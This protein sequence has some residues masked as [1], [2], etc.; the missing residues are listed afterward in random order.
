MLWKLTQLTGVTSQ[1]PTWLTVSDMQ[2]VLHPLQ[3]AADRL[4]DQVEKFAENLDRMNV[5]K[6]QTPQKDCRTVLPLVQT[7]RSIAKA[8]VKSLEK[9]TGSN[10]QG[11]LDQKIKR[12]L[13]I[14]EKSSSNTEQSN[15]PDRPATRQDLSRWKQEEQTWHLLELMLQVEFPLQDVRGDRLS[16][17]KTLKRPGKFA[18]H[19]YS[20]EKEVWDCFLANDD[21]AWERHTVVEWLKECA[22]DSDQDIASVVKQLENDA[23]RGDG[24]WA[25]SWL[26]TKEA[27][28][29]QKRLR[30]WPRALNPDIEPSLMNSE[31]TKPLVTQLDPDA[32]SRQDRNLELKDQNFERATW[33]A[34]WEMVRRGN[35]WDY[36]RDW[37]QERVDGWRAIAMRGDPRQSLHGVNAS[38]ST[39]AGW[40][41]RLLWRKICALNG[42]GGRGNTDKHASAQGI[43]MD[44]YE[45]AVYGILGGYL[46]SVL[47]VCGNWNDYL[48][49]HYNSFLLRSFDNYILANFPERLSFGGDKT[50]PFRSVVAGGRTHSGNQLVEKMKTL[51][52]VSEGA[53]RPFK[54]LQG[55]LIGKSFESFAFK[56]GVRLSLLCN[57]GE[58]RSKT[59]PRMDEALLEDSVTAEIST[60]D[61]QMLRVITHMIIIFKCL[62][63]DLNE[64]PRGFAAENFIVAYIE[65]LSKAGKQQLLPLYASCLSPQRA[66]VCLGKQLPSI[67]DNAERLRIMQ[68]MRQNGIDVPSVLNKQLQMIVMD[69]TMESYRKKFPNLKILEDSEKDKGISLRRIRPGFLDG[70]V[71]NDQQDLISGFEWYLLLDGH[72]QQTMATGAVLYRYL[73]SKRHSGFTLNRLK[74]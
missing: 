46:P 9:S 37:C 41:S 68:L 45:A 36:I 54:M 15:Q 2:K 30:S 3:A 35:S 70:S 50:G 47:R 8:T 25:H 59:I 69:S 62:G 33:L 1:T 72:W 11:R 43:I 19:Q 74:H 32:S 55:S 6:V 12:R 49:G 10:R 71:T 64:S 58:K 44:K 63:L 66:L 22:E 28:K 34:C 20:S 5:N 60:D 21:L 4:G 40:H 48:F 24:L 14:P 65:F 53:K 7:Y 17:D 42:K 51:R 31:R 61:H 26:Y 29:F 56:H 57:S 27:I 73:L 13:E 23:D 39:G 52:G 18:V 38:P 16:L 67:L